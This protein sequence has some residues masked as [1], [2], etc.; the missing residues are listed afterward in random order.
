MYV[1]TKDLISQGGVF[2]LIGP[3]FFKLMYQTL[4][5]CFIRIYKPKK[6]VKNR[7]RP[8]AARFSLIDFEIPDETSGEMI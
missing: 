6:W 1:L 4:K 7:R 2:D 5:G 3:I 8:C